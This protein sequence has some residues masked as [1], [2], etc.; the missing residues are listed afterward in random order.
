[1]NDGLGRVRLFECEVCD[2]S[3]TALRTASGVFEQREH[4]EIL[5]ALDPAPVLSPKESLSYTPD[6]GCC[7]ECFEYDDTVAPDGDAYVCVA[8]S[9]RFDPSNSSSCESCG[10]RWFGWDTDDSYHTGCEHCDGYGSGG[11]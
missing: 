3:A 6:R 11:V 2:Y 7:G 4:S 8:C 1:V 5:N 9:A 10:Q